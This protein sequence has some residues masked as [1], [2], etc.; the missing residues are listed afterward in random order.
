M[1]NT[2]LLVLLIVSF[3]SINAQNSR[4]INSEGEIERQQIPLEN[5]KT[6]LDYFPLLNVKASQTDIDAGISPEGDYLLKSTYTLD[7]SKVLLANS[8]TNN[9]TVFD[10]QDYSILNNIPVGYRPFDIGITDNYAVVSC[11]FGDQIDVIDLSTMTVVNS[12]MTASGAQPGTVRISPDQNYAY[13]SCDINDQLEVIDLSTMQQLAP[14][15]NFPVFLTSISS[16]VSNGR[17]SFKF[18]SFEISSDGNYIVTADGENSIN[19]FNSNTG[20]LDFTIDGVGAA[21]TIGLSGD[22]SN[23]S[24]IAS[25]WNTNTLDCYQIDMQTFLITETVNISN[26]TLSTYEVASNMDGSKIYLGVSDNSGALVNFNTG[27]VTIFTNTYTPFWLGTTYDHLYAISG[28]N[29][30]SIVD[31]ENEEVIGTNWGNSQSYGCVSPTEYKVAAYDPL[32]YEGVLFYTFTDPNIVNL[33]DV[34]LSGDAL[35]GDA[36]YRVAISEDGSKIVSSNALSRNATLID[37]N[38]YTIE[39]IVDLEEDPH[40]VAISP[41]GNT[42]VLGGYDLNTIKIVDLNTQTLL[43]TIYTG[44]RPMMINISDDNNFAYVG[45]LKGNSVSIVSLDG[46]NSQLL[47][48]I[49]TGVIGLVYTGMGTR[50]AVVVDPTGEYILVAASFDDKVQIIDIEDQSI[51]KEIPVGDFPLKIAFNDTGDTALVLNYFDNTFNV[52]HIDGANSINLGTYSTGGQ[53]PLRIEYNTQSHHFGII[54]SGS[55]NLKEVFAP[56]WTPQTVASYGSYG[57]PIQVHYDIEGIPIVLVMGDD[58]PGFLV[59]EGEAVVLPAVPNFF[60]YCASQNKAV[61]CMPGPDYLTVVD[62]S[63]MPIAEFTSDSTL[64]YTG[65]TVT[66]TDLSLNTPSTWNWTFEGG[67]PSSSE[68]Q[69]PSVI[70]N[71][72]GYY[73]VS[74]IVENEEGTDEIIK[75]DYIHVILY[76]FVDEKGNSFEINLFPNPTKNTL[77]IDFLSSNANLRATIFTSQGRMI[78]TLMLD[79]KHSVI[80]TE[81]FPSG[82]YFLHLGNEKDWKIVKFIKQ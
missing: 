70:Y 39:G 52:L 76:D 47:T 30:F 33:N 54:H 41:D 34:V 10:A 78:K 20:N 59:R 40:A 4:Q 9:I 25:D 5:G 66:F 17:F 75:E 27:N 69:N 65:S 37:G 77:N 79:S 81:D 50:S 36:P 13:I 14:I 72:T 43:K 38:N 19:F 21:R 80:S 26:H 11:V 31:F 56:D 68:E 58:E 15:S 32:R 29:R 42:A 6:L 63:T 35:E 53:Y 18:S 2:L 82:V 16:A 64:V 45:N 24:V 67:D 12:F 73:D 62:Y 71:T 61:V 7:G 51:V 28:Q 44:Q 60:D 48:T 74:L 3:W 23:L 1:K 49:P 46:A 8:M 22:G 55:K 57:T